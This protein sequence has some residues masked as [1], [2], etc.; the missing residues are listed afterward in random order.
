MIPKDAMPIGKPS[1]APIYRADYED[2]SAWDD[3]E[4]LIE[5]FRWLGWAGVAV[6]FGVAWAV[7]VLCGL[8]G[9]WMGFQMVQP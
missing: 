4:A 7:T 9:T 8:I 6:A 3:R 1:S 5:F 2:D